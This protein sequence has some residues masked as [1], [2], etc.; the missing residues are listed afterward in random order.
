LTGVAGTRLLQLLKSRL[1]LAPQAPLPRQIK[2][3]VTQT[4]AAGALATNN[5]NTATPA[6]AAG[7]LI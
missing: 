1:L 5:E 4:D 3:T 6:G 2:I 7:A